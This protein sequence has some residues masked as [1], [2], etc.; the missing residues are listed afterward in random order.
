M[1]AQARDGSG[2]DI[3]L[4]EQVRELSARLSAYEAQL[5]AQEIQTVSHYTDCTDCSCDTI[6]CRVKD[7]WTHPCPG[8]YGDAELLLLKW[9]DTDGDDNQNELNSG[10]RY[11]IGYESS[12]G[13]TLRVRYFEFAIPDN[14]GTGN[15]QTEHLDLEYAGRFSLGHNWCGELSL[16]GRWATL[17][18]PTP[19]DYSDM[20]GPV[21]GLEV[22]SSLR[23]WLSLYGGAR[24]SMLFGDELEEVHPST[25]L[26]HRDRAR[27]GDVQEV[28]L[29]GPFL[30]HRRRGAAVY[31]RERRRGKLR[32]GRL[33][34]PL[35]HPPL[36][37]RAD[38]RYSGSDVKN[39]SGI[40][41]STIFPSSSCVRL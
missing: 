1:A 8:W 15:L 24:Y 36:T 39:E 13:R 40:D 14:V 32:P 37:Q 10:S 2:S 30:P 6:G 5:Q 29:H 34:A 7:C 3:P 33:G 23:R 9:T 31:L 12:K 41:R 19:R 25:F 11:T 20:L 26:D 38:A 4:S 17:S 18:N 21:V 28:R 16:G 27:R 22:R 35:R